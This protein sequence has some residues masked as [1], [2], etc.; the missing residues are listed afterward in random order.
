[1]PV[2]FNSLISWYFKKRIQ[3]V[4]YAVENPLEIQENL[5]K[6]LLFQGRQTE[7]GK[8]HGFDAIK[9][10]E[11]FQANVPI[12]DYEDLKP[13]IDRTMRGEQMILWPSE[14][15]WFAKSSGTTSDK[16]KFIPVTFEALD[17]CQ[18]KGARDL[19]TM[20]CHN[21]PNTKI[22]D[23]KGLLIGGSHEVNKYSKN[24]YYGDLSAVMMNNLPFWVNL[25]RTPSPDIA[26]MADWE[27]KMDKMVKTTRNQDVRSVS[28]VPTWTMLLIQKLI[29]QRGAESIL[30][31]WPNLEL[32][33]HG[34]V[35]F[36]PY[37]DQFQSLIPSGSM[38]YMETYNASE[39]FFGIQDSLISQGDMMLMMDYG[40]F[41]EF[42]PLDQMDK[43]E[44][45]AVMLK[46]VELYVPY[47]LIITTNAG[48]WRYNIGDTLVF[49]Q[50]APFKFRLTGRT[51]LYINAFGEELM[52]DNA[53]RA[54]DEACRKTNSRITEYTAAPVFLQR[55]EAGSHEWLIEFEK[56]PEDLLK[57]RNEL[58]KMLQSVN[59]DYE[60]KRAGDLALKAPTINIC[61]RGTFYN[62]MKKR[63]KL[64]GQHKVPRLSNDRKIIDDIKAMTST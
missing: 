48:L 29:D 47:A 43:E 27:Q 17:E 1:M 42:L 63:G 11:D 58:D 54:I 39:G 55:D 20:Y 61:E 26:L 10:Q 23:G 30:D 16:S 3:Q 32:Y 31:I 19:L 40:I 59:S 5:F 14:I 33:M 37:R 49:T 52:I 46:D 24:S 56:A 36:L 44:P 62:W 34:G 41:Y 9:S 64:G 7:F 15:K 21:N 38:H 53:E 6:E 8:I 45:K 2:L 18:F 60:A 12:S 51:R 28:G 25:L 4:Q 35:S 13:Y 50:K 57:F 22:F